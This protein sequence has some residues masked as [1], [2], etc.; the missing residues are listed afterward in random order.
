MGLGCIPTTVQLRDIRH[1]NI[2]YSDNRCLGLEVTF[3]NGHNDTLGRWDPNSPYFNRETVFDS[4]DDEHPF[5]SM[6][7]WMS[8]HFY[9]NRVDN[10]PIML[11]WS[12]YYNVNGI[13]VGKRSVGDL[14]G[15]KC[16]VVSVDVSEC[17]LLRF[18]VF[19]NLELI[20]GRS[21]LN[22]SSIM[23]ATS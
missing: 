7:I 13:S 17:F 20:C 1:I 6:E 18:E 12:S 3:S 2:W 11:A 21:F 15:G 5:R 14:K 22:G 8:D 4:G 10:S 23:F 19:G 9:E 16:L